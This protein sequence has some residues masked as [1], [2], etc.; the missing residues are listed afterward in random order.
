[1]ILSTVRARFFACSLALLAGSLAR[2]QD[3]AASVDYLQSVSYQ[4]VVT[5]VGPVSTAPHPGGG[6]RQTTPLQF[7]FLD[8]RDL[9]RSVLNEGEKLTGWALIALT[10]STEFSAAPKP[11]TTL[12]LAARNRVSGELRPIPGS[13][14]LTP[15][16]TA[17]RASTELRQAPATE[18]GELGPIVSRTANITQTAVLTQVIPG[19]G[20]IADAVGLLTHG[21]ILSTLDGA[22]NLGPVL[23]PSSATFR[24]SG[25]FESEG[26]LPDGMVEILLSLGTATREI[27]PV[28]TLAASE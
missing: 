1:M 15:G 23:R 28:T 21:E 2:A 16:D 18:G 4:M 26:E 3:N 17:T 19:A 25:R 9:I 10:N 24:A 5:R 14:L 27:V 6:T 8:N 7:A 20:R 13:F 12:R 11:L 22:T